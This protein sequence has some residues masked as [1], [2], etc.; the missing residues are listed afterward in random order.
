[1]ENK[2]TGRWW[3]KPEKLETVSKILE[4]HEK[5]SHQSVLYEKAL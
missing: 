3:G 4:D 5:T 2:D 1:M